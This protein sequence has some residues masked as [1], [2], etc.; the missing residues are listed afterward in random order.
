MFII[1]LVDISATAAAFIGMTVHQVSLQ[2]TVSNCRCVEVVRTPY[3]GLST[4]L[5]FP[6]MCIAS[7]IHWSI[8]LLP[9][10]FT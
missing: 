8:L 5:V 3:L 4:C 1:V 6:P 10:S 9:L 2:W 7:L